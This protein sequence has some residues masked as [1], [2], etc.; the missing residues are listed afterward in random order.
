M[1][2]CKWI[3]T[4]CSSLSMLTAASMD[5]IRYNW[6]LKYHKIVFRNG[7]GKYSLD[8]SSFPDELS[9]NK[10][11][12][13]KAYRT[14]LLIIDMISDL[15]VAASWKAYHLKMITDTKFSTWFQAWHK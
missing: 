12:F 14:W 10:S 13:W 4:R 2:S 7:A 9:L 3:S 5:H 11:E 15:R 6:S 1:P 8:E